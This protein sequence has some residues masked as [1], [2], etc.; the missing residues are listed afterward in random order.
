MTNQENDNNQRPWGYYT[1]LSDEETHK[2]KRITVYPGKR[3]SLQMHE[4]RSEHWF[5][6][7]GMAYM[8]LDEKKIEMTEGQ[9]VDIERKTG[10][11]IENIGQDYFGEDDILRLEDDYGR[12]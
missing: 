4:K 12:I 9:S 3:L 10:H 8:T 6:V 5:I 7:Q 11:R 1:I 2:V